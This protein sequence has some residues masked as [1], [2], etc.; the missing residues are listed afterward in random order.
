MTTITM[1]FPPDAPVIVSIIGNG[2]TFR[3]LESMPDG[4]VLSKTTKG[5]L[6]AVQGDEVIMDFVKW[7]R[8]EY[9]S[10]KR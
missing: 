1:R 7:I 4:S 10:E 5:E 6:L 2:A 8:R 3:R 9:G